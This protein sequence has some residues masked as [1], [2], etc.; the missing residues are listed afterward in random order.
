MVLQAAHEGTV[1]RAVPRG[2]G[3]VIN[4]GHPLYACASPG[5]RLTGK[6]EGLFKSWETRETE[7]TGWGEAGGG[8]GCASKSGNH[9]G[10]T[11][12][13]RVSKTY[14][15]MDLLVSPSCLVTLTTDP[16]SGVDH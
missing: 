10:C 12:V 4:G 15:Q 3:D 14:A 6:R 8:Q 7:R 5:C 1:D 16:F 13:L 9:S 2:L 11:L